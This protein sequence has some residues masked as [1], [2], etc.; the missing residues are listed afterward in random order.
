MAVAP[1]IGFG[2]AGEGYVRI[3]LVVDERAHRSSPPS[4]SSEFLRK[5][6]A[7]PVRPS[8]TPV[9]RSVDRA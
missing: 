9:P 4:G 5:A 6:A 7:E 2:P 3:A 1:G 8:H